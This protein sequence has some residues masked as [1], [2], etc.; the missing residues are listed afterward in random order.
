MVVAETAMIALRCLLVLVFSAA[1]AGKVRGEGAAGDF[2]RWVADLRI[3]PT[4]WARPAAV[5]TLVAEGAGA[6]LLLTPWTVMPGL[7]LAG[8]MLAVF[9]AA[10]FSVHHRRIAATCRCFG[11]S[12]APLGLRHVIRDA[13][14]ASAAL[15]GLAGAGLPAPPAP[16]L[17]LGAGCGFLLAVGAVYLDD[18]VM[19]FDF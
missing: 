15:V 14:L 19:L 18:I 4:A 6:A 2:V 8:G 17:A 16:G 5:A 10:A 7:V 13:A 3:V 11:R 1:L 12:D 9:A